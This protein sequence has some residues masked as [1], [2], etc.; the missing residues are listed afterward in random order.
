M[1]T[2]NEDVRKV[3]N[4]VNK[5]DAKLVQEMKSHDA[6]IAR[7][8]QELDL[9]PHYTTVEDIIKAIKIKELPQKYCPSCEKVV[10]V[11]CARCDQEL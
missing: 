5:L 10:S 11:R 7:I 8:A 2:L 6:E 9:P 3:L 4:E 1:T